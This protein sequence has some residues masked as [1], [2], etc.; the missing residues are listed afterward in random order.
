MGKDLLPAPGKNF[1]P[2]P[3]FQRV[4]VVNPFILGA[5][6]ISILA[7]M[8][9]QMTSGSDRNNFNYRIPPSWPPENDHQYSFRA[10][11][12]DITL[13]VMMTDLQP[14]QQAAAIIMCLGGSAREMARTMTPQ[15][16]GQG[17][18]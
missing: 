11:M 8:M 10:F 12:T 3:I 4:L 17:R 18:M 6:L 2:I 15:E 1:K 7:S 14:H 16:L 9:P 13:W 5:V